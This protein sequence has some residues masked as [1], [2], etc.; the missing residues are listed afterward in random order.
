M[1]YIYIRPSEGEPRFNLLAIGGGGDTAGPAKLY[2]AL[3]AG[4]PA[5]RFSLLCLQPTHA[6]VEDATSAMLW[7]SGKNP[8]PFV[9][10]GFGEGAAAAIQLSLF[11]SYLPSRVPALILLSP[12]LPEG[13]GLDH[14]LERIAAEVLIVQGEQD[15]PERVEASRALSAMGGPRGQ[16]YLRLL[17]KAGH[18][19]EEQ[20]QELLDLCSAFILYLSD[21][22]IP[23]G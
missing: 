19:L 3:S 2:E 4:I 22:V 23:K 7:L 20:G 18:S 9:L 8:G 17:P 6:H 11:F 5:L 16:R 21:K 13:E 10:L 14:G 12:V 1:P 15:L